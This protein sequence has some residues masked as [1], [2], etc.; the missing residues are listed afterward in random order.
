M[1]V[2]SQG[3][4]HTKLYMYIQGFWQLPHETP[5]S[6]R[7]HWNGIIKKLGEASLMPARFPTLWGGRRV[8][9][10]HSAWGTQRMP[11]LCC[12]I[13]QE[14]HRD[15]EKAFHHFQSACYKWPQCGDKPDCLFSHSHTDGFPI[16]VVHRKVNRNQTANHV[17]WLWL[18]LVTNITTITI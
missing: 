2:R 9:W 4:D 1:F 10:C 6:L 5:E 3:H 12:Q 11:K 16:V 15:R 17:S 7:P 13:R 18:I 8:S 14:L